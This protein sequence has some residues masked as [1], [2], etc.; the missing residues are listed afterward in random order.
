MKERIEFLEKELMHMENNNSNTYRKY[1]GELSF[2]KM[3]EKHDYTVL[4]EYINSST[5]VE[6]MCKNKHRRWVRP[7]DFKTRKIVCKKCTKITKVIE[8]TCDVCGLTFK[9]EYPNQ[10][11]CS[12]ECKSII[13]KKRICKN[14]KKYKEYRKEY[15]K[16]YRE[17]NKEK[18]RELKKKYREEN[19]EKIKQ[20]SKLYRKT[21]VYKI[22]RKNTKHKRKQQEKN[23]VGITVEQWKSC[24]EFFDY[25]CAYSGEQCDDLN[26]EHVVPLSK[27]GEHAYYNIVPCVAT[28]NSSKGNKDM[29]EWY[30]KQP[31][32]S[33][34]RLHK[35][36]EYMNLMEE[37]YL[38]DKVS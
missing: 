31:Y 22:Y 19:K 8:K 10:R 38:G 36:Y 21:E 2:L 25:R 6:I 26:M 17:E 29:E 18:I 9:T 4:T 35:I 33:E 16:K 23:G 13:K 32:F 30:R 5:K 12:E 14:S 34:E 27:G 11:R 3:L 7:N 20:Y 1:N 15:N 37:I 24:L 28:Y